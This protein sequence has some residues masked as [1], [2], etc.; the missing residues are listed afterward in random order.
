MRLRDSKFGRALVLETFAK[1]GGYILG[2]RVD[3]QERIN[4]VFQEIQ[5]LYQIYSVGPNFGVDFSLEAETPSIDQLLQTKV[6]EDLELLDD[7]A[8]DSHAIAAYYSETAPDEEN[9]YDTIQ[10]DQRLG[11]AIEALVEGTSIEQLWRVV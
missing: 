11:L 4:D 1:S 9:R 6:N 2:F 3:P 7:Q 8:D 5:S 10:Y